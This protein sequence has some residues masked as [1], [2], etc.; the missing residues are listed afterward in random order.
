MAAAAV[1][2]VGGG[3]GGGGDRGD[4][5]GTGGGG[6][7]DRSSPAADTLNL[8]FKLSLSSLAR[9]TATTTI[10]N[11]PSRASL[12]PRADLTDLAHG[13]EDLWQV[14]RCGCCWRA[15]AHQ[16]PLPLQPRLRRPPLVKCPAAAV[17]S[18]HGTGSGGLRRSR[19]SPTCQSRFLRPGVG[20]HPP[21]AC[22]GAA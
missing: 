1:V 4:S 16:P 9:S 12:E 7:G 2:G 19:R 11:V 21:H 17:A 6:G 13:Q 8:S 18:Y 14:W 22:R 20:E 15:A 3:C 10:V 5:R